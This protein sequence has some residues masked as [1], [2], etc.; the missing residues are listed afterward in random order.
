MVGDIA[1]L[2]VDA[3]VNAANSALQLGSGVA[4]AIRARGGPSIQRECDAIG[5]CP[6]GEAVVTGAGDLPAR[7][8][9][10]AVGPL[11]SDPDAD[12]RLASAC[13]S[14]LRRAAGIGAASV[15]IPAISTGVFGFPL[16]RAARIL[17]AEARTFAAAHARPERIVFCLRDAATRDV[18]ARALAATDDLG[19]A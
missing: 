8:V 6:V 17:V 4:G 14:A 1:A 15:A 19:P 11:G 7:W 12:V 9:I 5:H 3:V 18:F 13:R 10:H 16:V 2:D